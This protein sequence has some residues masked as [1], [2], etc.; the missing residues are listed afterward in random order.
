MC[1]LF[2]GHM[3]VI[4]EPIPVCDEQLSGNIDMQDI[5]D[6]QEPNTR[7]VVTSTGTEKRKD[8]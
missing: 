8:L 2:L 3:H 5:P 7:L 4:H 6:R 1:V